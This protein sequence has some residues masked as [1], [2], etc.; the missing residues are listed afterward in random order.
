MLLRVFVSDR[1]WLS[2][3]AVAIAPS[4]PLRRE[5]GRPSPLVTKGRECS[6]GGHP[7][8]ELSAFGHRLDLLKYGPC[9]S[10]HRQSLA[11]AWNFEVLSCRMGRSVKAFG[12]NCALAPSTF[13]FLSR[14]PSPPHSKQPSALG[15]LHSSPASHQ[16]GYQ[17]YLL[18]HGNR[19]SRAEL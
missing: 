6:S 9:G 16:K 18:G 19:A 10:G 14:A 15:V 1:H 7:C 5:M 4:S 8:Q 13:Y 17:G 3:A 2:V 11:A 12:L